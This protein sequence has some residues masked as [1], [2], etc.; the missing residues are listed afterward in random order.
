MSA[1]VEEAKMLVLSRCNIKSFTCCNRNFLLRANTYAETK[2]HPNSIIANPSSVLGGV[3]IFNY[4]ND[5]RP[6]LMER[7]SPHILLGV[8][9]AVCLLYLLF[10]WILYSF[11][12]WVFFDKSKTDI[13]LESYST[14]IYYLGFALFPFVLFLVYFDLNV[15]FLV[16]IGCVLV[17][18]TKILMFYKW[19][20]L[21][22]CNIYGVF[23]LILYFCALE[24]VPCLIVYQGMI[25]LNN[26]LIINF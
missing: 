12:G 26:V 17:I 14:L 19:L 9:V 23:L 15:T 5:I 4:F 11:L 6:A 22:S 13:W 24:I 1:A 2:K 18:F 16:S 21:F 8:Y 10:K 25:Q 20:K 7:V 3:C